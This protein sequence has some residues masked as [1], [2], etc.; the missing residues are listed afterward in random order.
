MTHRLTLVAP[1]LCVACATA[2]PGEPARPLE[3]APQASSAQLSGTPRQRFVEG[4]AVDLARTSIAAVDVSSVNGTRSPANPYHGILNA[5][6]DGEHRIGEIPYSHW[7]P[8]GGAEWVDVRFDEPATVLSIRVEA[9]APFSAHAS[10]AGGGEARWDSTPRAPDAPQPSEPASAF[11]LPAF[12]GMLAGRASDHD[13]VLDPPAADVRALRLSFPDVQQVAEIRVMGFAREGIEYS[14]G[15]P[16]VVWTRRNSEL[17]AKDAFDA[18][19]I[20]R[21]KGAAARVEEGAGSTTVTY[22]VDGVDMFRAIVSKVDGSVATCD[23]VT[24]PARAGS[25]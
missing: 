16:R 3:P 17:A 15:A 5:F 13:V 22:H 1:A 4:Q 11:P 25:R 19:W 2:P 12:E 20:E 9:G 10:F 8:E 18:W 14:P 6:D 7:T 23:L 21:M 24:D